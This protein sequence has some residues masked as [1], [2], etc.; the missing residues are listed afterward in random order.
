M[1]CAQRFVDTLTVS[2]GPAAGGIILGTVS[3]LAVSL[4]EAVFTFN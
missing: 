4:T 3:P 1:V 2:P